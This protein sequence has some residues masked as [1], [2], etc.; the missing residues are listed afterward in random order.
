MERRLL[1]RGRNEDGNG[2]EDGK[3]TEIG[4]GTVREMETERIKRDKWRGRLSA[5]GVKT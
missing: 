3:R 2:N 5:K 1:S 4:I